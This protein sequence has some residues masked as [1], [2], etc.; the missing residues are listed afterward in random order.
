MNK[1]KYLIL[2]ILFAAVLV[3]AIL[4]YRWLSE[5]YV[6]EHTPPTAGNPEESETSA[7]AETEN[8]ETIPEV[9]RTGEEVPDFTVYDMEGNPVKLSDYT[10][11]PVVLNFWATWCMPCR[12]EM[13]AFEK[14]YT[15][16]GEE[17]HFLMVNCTDGFRDTVDSVKAFI[18]S[19]GYTFPVYFD[20][21]TDAAQSF[22]VN[23]IPRTYFLWEDG[24]LMEEAIGMLTHEKLNS[25]MEI[26]KGAE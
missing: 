20:S 1:L 2:L 22:V 6:P 5:S 25:Y 10:G 17:I 15:E 3:F 12:M 21:D 11:K 9:E 24:T 14:A 16:Y 26:L 18:S 19:N 7:N 4:G 13:A 23:S 8:T